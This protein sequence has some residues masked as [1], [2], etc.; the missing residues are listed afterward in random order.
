M[1]YF[2][3]QR[4]FIKHSARTNPDQT[5]S[6]NGNQWYLTMPAEECLRS[7]LWQE[8]KAFRVLFLRTTP[9]TTELWD[10][11]SVERDEKIKLRDE[12]QEMILQMTLELRKVF[13]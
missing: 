1:S 2:T 7:I 4:L 6:W 10:L 11:G 8:W 5:A 13:E 3:I 9:R 12:L